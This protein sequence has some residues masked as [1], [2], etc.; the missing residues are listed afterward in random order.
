MSLIAL[1]ERVDVSYQTCLAIFDLALLITLKP[2]KNQPA[3][4][5]NRKPLSNA[6]W[7]KCCAW[8]FCI[9]YL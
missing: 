5:G 2:F 1:E 3:F 7:L 4:F 6:L 9:V 8:L